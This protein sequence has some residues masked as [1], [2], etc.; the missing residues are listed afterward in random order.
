MG[1]T[2]DAILVRCL[3]P[4]GFECEGHPMVNSG[5]EAIDVIILHVNLHDLSE[6]QVLLRSF[7]FLDSN[8]MSCNNNQFLLEAVSRF[9]RHRTLIRIDK[10]LIAL[11]SSLI[12]PFMPYIRHEV[13]FTFNPDI[14]TTSQAVQA[15]WSQAIAL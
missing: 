14:A 1:W 9:S 8:Y 3:F 10:C 6:S 15:N 5:P 2:R 4:T 7:M 12:I 13:L 11:N